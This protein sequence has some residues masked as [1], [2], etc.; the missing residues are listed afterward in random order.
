[1]ILLGKVLG[2]SILIV[3]NNLVNYFAWHRDN[4]MEVE[5]T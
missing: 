1:L 4:L 5:N 2:I 3:Q